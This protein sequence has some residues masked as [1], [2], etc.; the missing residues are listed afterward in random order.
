MFAAEIKESFLMAMH[1]LAAHK[2][3]SALTLL[4]VLVG[5]F[6]IVVVMTAMRILQRNI[7][8]ELTQLG[9]HTFAV[10][11][12]PGVYFGGPEGFEKFWRRKHINIQQGLQV[13]ERATLASGVGF[14]AS[15]WNGEVTSRFE[16]SAPT[17]SVL[18]ESP[19]SFAAKN[20][21]IHE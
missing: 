15:L 10:Q 1:A 19:G 16:K 6:S 8:S 12:W 18:G 14:E 21:L 11:K 20:W 9:S 7:E 13:R 3:R 5:V 17:V 4:G 2:L